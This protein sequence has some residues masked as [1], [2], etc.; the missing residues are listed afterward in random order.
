MNRVLLLTDGLAKIH[1]HA[2]ELPRLIR[3]LEGRI[4]RIHGDDQPWQ[5]F[6]PVSCLR[7]GLIGLF[8]R[9]AGQEEESRQH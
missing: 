4:R 2:G 6:L 5:R 8:F 1:A 9:A 3:V 7:I